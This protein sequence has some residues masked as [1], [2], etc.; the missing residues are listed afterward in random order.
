MPYIDVSIATEK[1]SESLVASVSKGIGDVMSDILNKEPSLVSVA[2]KAV[3]PVHWCIANEPQKEGATVFVAAMITQGTNTVE[4]K[5]AAQRAIFACLTDVLG[6][7]NEASY[8]VLNEIP[9]TDWGYAGRSQESRKAVIQRTESGVIDSEYYRHKAR[10][11]QSLEIRASVV[12][13]GALLHRF[14]SVRRLL[15]FE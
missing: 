11:L 15:K 1:L 8:I 13:V 7:L 4:E 2:V 14:L 12:K 9:P 6:E 10:R 3:N 5:A